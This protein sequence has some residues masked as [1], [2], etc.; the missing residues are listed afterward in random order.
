MM[1]NIHLVEACECTLYLTRIALVARRTHT[2]LHIVSMA[3]GESV[4]GA[5]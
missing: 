5:L 2:Q 4:L 1:Y 3:P